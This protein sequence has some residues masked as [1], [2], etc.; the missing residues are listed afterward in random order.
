MM[1]STLSRWI[2]ILNSL[3]M[4]IKINFMTKDIKFLSKMS[5][6]QI[7][8]ILGILKQHELLHPDTSS[9][10]I[11]QL[12]L[13]HHESEVE[14]RIYADQ[15]VQELHSIM[16][17]ITTN[18]I[19][20]TGKMAALTNKER[21]TSNKMIW[22]IVIAGNEGQVLEVNIWEEGKLMR[23]KWLQLHQG[24]NSRD[25]ILQIYLSIA[26]T[27]MILLLKKDL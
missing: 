13:R 4:S 15:A 17:K 23:L 16:I 26:T 9:S 3:N 11:L 5:T 6:N 21:I 8:R 19:N 27:T 24:I 10:I 12:K 7:T 18:L 1:T 25:S 20:L 14:G 22:C 2:S